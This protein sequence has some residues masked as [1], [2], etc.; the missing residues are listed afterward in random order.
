[1][2]ETGVPVPT[3]L[4]TRLREVIADGIRYWEPRRLVFNAVLAVIVLVYFFLGLPRSRT[5]LSIELV[6]VVFLLAV[7]ANICYCVAYVGD[8]FV[9]V[10]GL[11]AVW[12]RWRWILFA[13]GLAFA[14]IVTRWIAMGM[15]GI[16]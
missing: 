6:F 13:I 8:V 12:R 16:V 11:S 7:L 1:M 4:G 3:D 14:A 5:Q 9:Q 15:F 2:S 10:A